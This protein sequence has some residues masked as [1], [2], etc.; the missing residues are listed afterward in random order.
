MKA[1][2]RAT[3]L[4]ASLVVATGAHAQAYPTKPVQIIVPVLPGDTCDMIVRLVAAKMSE[5]LG[6]QLV[7]ENRPGAG[8]MIGHTLIS[9]AQPDGYTLGCGSSGGMAVVPHAFKDVS[10]NSAKDFTPIAMMA[11]NFV[12]LVV[13][14]NSSMRTVADLLQQ[15]KQNPGKVTFGSN[16]EGGYLHFVTER[17]RSA[18]GFTYLHVP[19]KGFP[20][21][22]VELMGERLDASFGSFPDVLPFV[23]SGRL[24]ILGIARPTRLPNY[25]DIPT[26]AETVPGYVTGGW[27]GIIGPA[28]IPRPIVTLLN[29]EANAALT[30]PD[31]RD[32]L[33]SQGLELV[34]E[35]PEFFGKIVQDDYAV[36]GK[37]AR[38][39]GLKPQ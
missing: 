30:A 23:Q 13:P 11:R 22:T 9:K 25:P 4:V 5:K 37:I 19:F 12:A 6:Q 34:A 38:D 8:G 1:L 31:I 39:I 18:A 24:R 21:I 27:F 28:G 10:Y 15:A 29:R 32:K 20:P 2:L 17:F 26:I 14:P 3:L 16:G 33:G 35:S 7:A 36:Y